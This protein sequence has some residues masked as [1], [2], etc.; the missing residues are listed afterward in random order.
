VWQL[1]VGLSRVGD[2]DG[3]KVQVID[4]REHG[5]FDGRGGVWTVNIV[6]PEVL[7]EAQELLSA[8]LAARSA[9]GSCDGGECEPTPSMDAMEC[10]VCEDGGG[11]PRASVDGDH[12][13]VG[14]DDVDG[15]A[16]DA[17][18]ERNV[19]TPMRRRGTHVPAGLLSRQ[20][21]WGLAHA[22]DYLA[23]TD[24]EMVDPWDALDGA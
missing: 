8:S 3:V 13:S 20:Q 12:G 19:L 15:D 4:T 6:Y 23:S 2:P 11:E 10:D 5:R 9:S 21:A 14:G 22:S 1:Y 7:A 17:A 24:S 16:A 18:I